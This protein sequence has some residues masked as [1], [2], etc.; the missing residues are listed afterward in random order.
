MSN[1]YRKKENDQPIEVVLGPLKVKGPIGLV[2]ALLLGLIV[3]IALT[4][5]DIAD[6]QQPSILIDPVISAAI[7]KT[8][9]TSTPLPRVGVRYALTG[10]EIYPSIG[11][12]SLKRRDT[13]IISIEGAEG[14]KFDWELQPDGSGVL[15]PRTGNEALFT[16]L[17]EVDHDVASLIKACEPAPASGFRE[18]LEVNILTSK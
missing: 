2:G 16:S 5:F 10:A 14:R 8:I 17:S 12:Y 6:W 13:I 11:A 1:P 9:A 4:L 18:C 7:T 3:G 15:N